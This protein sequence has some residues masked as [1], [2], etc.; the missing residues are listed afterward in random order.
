MKPEFENIPLIKNE[1]DKQFEMTVDGYKAFIQY[2]E[3]TDRIALVHTEVPE[4][5]SGRGIGTALVEK[6]LEQIKTTGKPLMPY[7]PF[8]FAYIKNHAKWKGMVSEKFPYY[9]EL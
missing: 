6:T 5:L 8:I 9:D 1:A 2:Q 4:E 3:L 7:C